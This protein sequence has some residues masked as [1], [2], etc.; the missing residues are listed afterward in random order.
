[1]DL[2]ELLLGGNHGYQGRCPAFFSRTLGPWVLCE[3]TFHASWK[4][5]LLQKSNGFHIQ[6]ADSDSLPILS[7]L[8][9][10]EALR[11]L[12]EEFD[13]TQRHGRIVEVDIVT[14]ECEPAIQAKRTYPTPIY[15][16]TLTITTVS[17]RVR[18]AMKCLCM[19]MTLFASFGRSSARFFMMRVLSILRS[20]GMTA[21]GGCFVATSTMEMTIDC[22]FIT[23]MT[24]TVR[25][26]LTS[27]I[28]SKPAGNLAG[29][30]EPSSFT[31]ANSIVR[32]KIIASATAKGL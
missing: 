23:L 8:M 16:V 5:I 3:R 19:R 9:L 6:A 26:P 1:M 20:L 7:S 29:P 12:A 17:R 10:R 31:G 18:T 21:L 25:G 32:R 30:A 24:S 14:G 28:P 27:T 11:S 2:W 22:T 4:M 13:Y 15:F